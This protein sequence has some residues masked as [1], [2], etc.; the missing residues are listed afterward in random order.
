MEYLKNFVEFNE[1]TNQNSIDFKISSEFNKIQDYLDTKK[2]YY[3][4][5]IKLPGLSS[6]FSIF[7]TK[8][9]QSKI[10]GEIVDIDFDLNKKT[11]T[12]DQSI[13]IG[14]LGKVSLETLPKNDVE[15]ILETTNLEESLIN[16]YSENIVKFAKELVKQIL[17]Y[18]LHVLKKYL[19]KL[20]VSC[21]YK[22]ETSNLVSLK[23]TVAFLLTSICITI[24]SL[25]GVEMD[26]TDTSIITSIMFLIGKLAGSLFALSKKF[27]QTTEEHSK[28]YTVNDFFDDISDKY[29][30]IVK[31]SIP[32]DY[33]IEIEKW[34]NTLGSE[35]KEK[36]S[37]YFK[38]L[39][40]VIVKE[41]LQKNWVRKKVSELIGKIKEFV[42][43][44]YYDWASTD[45]KGIVEI[46]ENILS[47]LFK[48]KKY[49]DYPNFGS[50]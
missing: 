25:S 28:F 11:S 19:Y 16:E 20:S 42:K 47:E 48:S 18:P 34:M 26:L 31:K 29:K 13:S 10:L 24:K 37:V 14:E 44:D 3:D 39:K 33:A 5:D 22:F 15:K 27:M 1:S 46:L 36:I 45:A 21:G 8:L 41:N 32:S 17:T 49:Q 43:S 12:K 7:N 2:K 9:T 38:I 4:S 23:A 35:S 50:E 40:N 30:S 6:K